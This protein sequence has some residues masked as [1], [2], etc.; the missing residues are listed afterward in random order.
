M[1][2]IA[3]AVGIILI[4]ICV[5]MF[6]K[7]QSNSEIERRR[8]E[9][10]KIRRLSERRMMNDDQFRNANVID[11]A[12]IYDGPNQSYNIENKLQYF[13]L[14]DEYGVELCEK[15]SIL[16]PHYDPL[17]ASCKPFYRLYPSDH[18]AGQ[19][20]VTIGPLASDNSSLRSPY[21]DPL[22]STWMGQPTADT[23][24]LHTMSIPDHRIL[25]G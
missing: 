22:P 9:T 4:I 12:S 8:R 3:L 17:Q 11:I 7:E 5:F 13:P 19:P 24:M 25:T 20:G 10:E 6:G 14:K 1:H 23:F 2:R 21:E 15:R 16:D 18:N